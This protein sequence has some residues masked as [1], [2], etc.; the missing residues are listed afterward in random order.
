MYVDDIVISEYEEIAEEKLVD[1][2]FE[3]ELELVTGHNSSDLW[4]K[5]SDKDIR[6]NILQNIKDVMPKNGF[7][8]E[9]TDRYGSL[10]GKV[11]L[12]RIPPIGFP[13]GCWPQVRITTRP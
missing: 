5:S 3:D 10:I 11:K 4:S 9:A 1:V 8:L 2:D 12:G 6:V 7:C 13:I